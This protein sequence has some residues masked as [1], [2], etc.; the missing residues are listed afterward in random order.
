MPP[1]NERTHFRE[2][3]N[4]RWCCSLLSDI[5]VGLAL[6]G[7]DMMSPVNHLWF[8]RK[9]VLS[10]SGGISSS[11]II[12]SFSWPKDSCFDHFQHS[13]SNVL[14]FKTLLFKKMTI[15]S[16]CTLSKNYS[17][18]CHLVTLSILSRSR[19]YFMI[20]LFTE[21]EHLPHEQALGN[22]SDKK[23][24]FNRQKPRAEPGLK[25]W[26]AN[27]RDQLAWE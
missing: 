5:L 19:P 15:N 11:D 6:F 4:H 8:I 13:N 12:H 14:S 18:K 22:S 17:L 25:S 16:P 1:E 23:L 9:L 27:C 3:V 26:A 24:P 20:N 21:V 2:E 10:F 7:H